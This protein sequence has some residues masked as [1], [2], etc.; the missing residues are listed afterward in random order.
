MDQP[1]GRRVWREVI[2]D[3]QPRRYRALLCEAETRYCELSGA[4]IDERVGYW[5]ALFGMYVTLLASDVVPELILSRYRRRARHR[6]VLRALAKDI[7]G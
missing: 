7:E 1:E 4:Q 2:K 6:H 5:L 3:L